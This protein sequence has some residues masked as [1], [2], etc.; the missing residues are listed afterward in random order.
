MF[1]LNRQLQF[2]FE[3]PVQDGGEQGVQLGGGLGLDMRYVI[4]V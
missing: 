2:P 4:N 1:C 3:G